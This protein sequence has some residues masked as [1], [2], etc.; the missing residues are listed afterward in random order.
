[1]TATAASRSTCP[2]NVP[3]YARSGPHLNH[4]PPTSKRRHAQGDLHRCETG[5]HPGHHDETG[6]G[7]RRGKEQTDRTVR[8]PHARVGTYEDA[9]N[10]SAPGKAGALTMSIQPL[11]PA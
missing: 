8:Y 9:R 5:K 10:R 7:Q 2:L 4:R 3:C 1:M 11:S 6:C